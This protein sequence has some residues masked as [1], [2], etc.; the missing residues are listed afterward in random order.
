VRRS[1]RGT[2][3]SRARGAG[4]TPTHGGSSSGRSPPSSAVT[5]VRLS[6]LAEPP[7]LPPPAALIFAQP[8]G[9]MKGPDGSPLL[10]EVERNQAHFGHIARGKVAGFAPARG[11]SI[12]E[13][14]D[15]C[16]TARRTSYQAS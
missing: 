2:A 8:V 11:S 13:L 15:S 7:E 3:D 10:R 1:R 14:D 16:K 6:R 5:K 12:R 9:R 4:C